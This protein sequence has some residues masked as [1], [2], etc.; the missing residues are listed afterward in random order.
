MYGRLLH[1]TT[2]SLVKG[3]LHVVCIFFLLCTL[4]TCFIVCKFINSSCILRIIDFFHKTGLYTKDQR[5]LYGIYAVYFPAP[6]QCT[7]AN[8]LKSHFKTTFKAEF[9]LG[10]VIEEF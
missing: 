10:I 3:M 2:E 9:Y 1:Y 5:R 6:V 8:L 7:L 4:C